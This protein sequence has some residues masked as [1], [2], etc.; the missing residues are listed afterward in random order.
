MLKGLDILREAVGTGHLYMW[1]ERSDLFL[2]FVSPE[3]L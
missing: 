1:A 3:D 2:Q